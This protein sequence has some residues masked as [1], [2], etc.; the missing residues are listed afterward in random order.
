MKGLLGKSQMDPDEAAIF[1]NASSIHTFGMQM[2]IDV[3]FLARNHE[4]KRIFHQVAPGRL[5]HCTSK[6]TIEFPSGKMNQSNVKE[7]DYLF[8]FPADESGQVVVEY[9]LLI[10]V[11]VLGIVTAF[12]PFMNEIQNFIQSMINYLVDL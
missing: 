11:L 3:V 5:V 12:Y 7:K 6:I 2:P 8:F 1:Y 10:A 9:A 4:I